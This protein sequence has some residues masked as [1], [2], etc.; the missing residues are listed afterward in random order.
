MKPWKPVCNRERL[1]RGFA[2]YVKV[3]ATQLSAWKAKTRVNHYSVL[4]SNLSRYPRHQWQFE[5]LLCRSLQYN[6]RRNLFCARIWDPK[7][8]PNPPC[9]PTMFDER[10]AKRQGWV[11]GWPSWMQQN[12]KCYHIFLPLHLLKTK[13]MIYCH[14]EWTPVWS[15]VLSPRVCHHGNTSQHSN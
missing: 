7:I 5:S 9:P 4:L 14:G 11:R 13:L 12:H 1:F 8:D 15:L 2:G 6:S 3:V 10:L